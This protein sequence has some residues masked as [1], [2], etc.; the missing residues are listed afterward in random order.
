MHIG[1]YLR[2]DLRGIPPWGE[3]G[4]QKVAWPLWRG[5]GPGEARVRILLLPSP[6]GSLLPGDQKMGFRGDFRYQQTI[7]AVRLYVAEQTE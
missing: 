3:G 6:V 5:E 4:R 1:A 2:G 7:G